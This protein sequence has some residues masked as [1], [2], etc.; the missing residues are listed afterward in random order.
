MGS[1]LRAS[2]SGWPAADHVRGM[3]RGFVHAR[4]EGLRAVLLT[5]PQ[6]PEQRDSEPHTADDRLPRCGPSV[7]IVVPSAKKTKAMLVSAACADTPTTIGPRS[8]STRACSVAA[9]QVAHVLRRRSGSLGPGMRRAYGS[10]PRRPICGSAR[11]HRARQAAGSLDCASHRGGHLRVLRIGKVTIAAAW[12]RRCRGWRGC[13][14]TISSILHDRISALR[15][16]WGG[17]AAS[18]RERSDPVPS[19]T[20]GRVQCYDWSAG[21]LGAPES[22]PR[23]EILVVDLIGLFHPQVM[24]A[25]DVAIWCDVELDDAVR[26]GMAR[27]RALGRSHEA[28]WTDIW[29]PNELDFEQ[30][31][32]PREHAD[33]LYA[34]SR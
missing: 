22:L 33:V 12:S 1:V 23:A 34:S 18:H 24:P 28:L 10:V 16:G 5:G 26:R 2:A 9:T 15:M 4:E 14:A 20:A 30:R 32:R 3:R 19:R 8:T 25:L 17:P 27:D 7:A 21:A 6:P 13:A 31:F 29:V 11:S